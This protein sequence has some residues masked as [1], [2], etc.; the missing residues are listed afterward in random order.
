MSTSTWFARPGTNPGHRAVTYDERLVPAGSRVTVTQ[1]GT[2]ETTEVELKVVGLLPNRAYG[3]HVHTQ[4]CGLRP[5]STGVHY[6]NRVDPH[7]PSVD[8]AY[9]NK[10]NEVWLGFTTDKEG[11]GLGKSTHSWRFRQGEARSV[12]LHEHAT[13]TGQ[14]VAGT[15]GKAVACFSV[16]FRQGL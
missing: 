12:V 4:P 14:G 2:S 15:A 5:G 3:T 11:Q 8:P 6:Q 10:E 16:P 9:A 7:Q 13:R 1:R